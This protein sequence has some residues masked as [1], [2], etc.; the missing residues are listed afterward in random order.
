MSRVT[1]SLEMGL[2]KAATQTSAFLNVKIAPY[3]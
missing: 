1:W 2:Q 3:L